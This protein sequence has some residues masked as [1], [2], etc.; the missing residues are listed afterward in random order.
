VKKS[1][2]VLLTAALLSAAG[3]DHTDFNFTAADVGGSRHPGYPGRGERPTAPS[4]DQVES[5]LEHANPTGSSQ[6]FTL[7]QLSVDSSEV[8]VKPA[9][10]AKLANHYAGHTITMADLNNA[11]EQ[12]TRYCRTHGYP[13]AAAYLPSQSTSD[14]TLT[15]KILPGRYG[16]INL[17][18]QSG[19]KDAQAQSYLR[20]L[21]AGEVITTKKLETALYNLSDLGGVQAT[22]LLS[23]GATVGASDVTVKLYK[24]KKNVVIV[25]AENYGSASS[26]RYRYGVQDTLNNLTGRGD[27]LSLGGLISNHNLRNYAINYETP[28][29]PSGTM[30]GIGY[31]RM[32]YDL[33]GGLSELGATGKADTYS[34]Y[35]KTPLFVTTDNSLYV[36]YGYNY[37]KLKDDIDLF[38]VTTEKHS[39]AFFAGVNGTYQKRQGRSAV[40]SDRL[41]RHFGFGFG[42][43]PHCGTR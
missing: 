20:G 13:A 14:G 24:G 6:K 39:H 25:Y 31:S 30:V 23:P 43:R 5:Q 22:G 10:L 19:I 36:N 37:R 21:K 12:L 11:T 2:Q 32:D 16:K 27:K 7:R 4:S 29:G 42:L 34:I 26:G 8:K 3:F 1:K 17:D 40:R 9:A 33:G 18:N 41:P 28:T 38:D 35:G 15:V